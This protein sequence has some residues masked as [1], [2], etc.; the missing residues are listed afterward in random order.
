MNI[1]LKL[2]AVAAVL[3]VGVVIGEK[4]AR[5]EWAAAD[6]ARERAQS[7]LQGAARRSMAAAAD[8]HEADRLRLN[9]QLE[10]AQRGLQQQLDTPVICPPTGSLRFGSIHVP[11]GVLERLRHAGADPASD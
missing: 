6:L 10:E 5:G 2:A 3:S 4:H 8:R 11:A 7:A 9:R 1:Y